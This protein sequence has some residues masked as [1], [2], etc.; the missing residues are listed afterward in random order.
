MAPLL[1]RLFPWPR[2]EKRWK[3]HGKERENLGFFSKGSKE[4]NFAIF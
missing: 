4:S 2:D 3:N 1:R